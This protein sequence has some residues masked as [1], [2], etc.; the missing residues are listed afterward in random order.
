MKTDGY[1]G[2]EVYGRSARRQIGRLPAMIVAVLAVTGLGATGQAVFDVFGWRNLNAPGLARSVADDPRE[3]EARQID[4]LVAML[5]D[6]RE[7]VEAMK[8]ARGR[9]GKVA[10]HADGALA[11]LRK[12]IDEK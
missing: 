5:R 8:R 3:P 7:S 11:K 9:G 10:E 12:A 2:V 1:Q 6:A 4:A